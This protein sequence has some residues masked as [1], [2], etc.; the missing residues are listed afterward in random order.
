MPE[1]FVAQQSSSH[2]EM[3]QSGFGDTR[4]YFEDGAYIA[5]PVAGPA[6]P[7]S[8]KSLM[9]PQEAFAAALKARFLEQRRQLDIKPSAESLAKL[10]DKHPT[11][12]PKN[13]SRAYNNWLRALRTTSPLP[14]QVRALE[15]SGALRLLAVIRNRFLIREQDIPMNL[16]AWIWSLLARLDDVGSIDSDQISSL[17]LFGKRAVLVQL[18]FRDPEAAA[19]LEELAVAEGGFYAPKRPKL[20]SKDANT[21]LSEDID[22]SNLDADVSAS[23]TANTRKDDDDAAKRTN[24]LATLDTIIVLVGDVFRQ[25]DLLEFR[26]SWTEESEPNGEVHESTKRDAI[27]SAENTGS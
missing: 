13:D 16:S 7:E 12:F 2:S 25:R 17:R 22:A 9:E 18:S 19:Q 11:S 3:Y 1:F 5:A 23:E 24:T 15:K 6:L 4:G 20:E 8:A 27:E 26:Q 10:S 14:T 21:H